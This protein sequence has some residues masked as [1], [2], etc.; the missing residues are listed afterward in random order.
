MCHRISFKT[1]S[2]PPA[3]RISCHSKCEFKYLLCKSN[4][5]GNFILFQMGCLYLWLCCE[6]VARYLKVGAVNVSGR[7]CKNSKSNLYLVSITQ[8]LLQKSTGESF[9][10]SA[11]NLNSPTDAGLLHSE[12]RLP[13]QSAHCL[14]QLASGRRANHMLVMAFRRSIVFCLLVENLSFV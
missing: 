11:T 3:L 10:C 9:L 1:T 4:F 13:T 2:S 8:A 12:R 7:V 6:Y 5:G 14:N